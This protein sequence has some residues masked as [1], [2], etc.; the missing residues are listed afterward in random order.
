VAITTVCWVV[1]AYVGP[2]TD[3]GVLVNFWRKVRPFGPGW[4]PVRALVGPAALEAR[5]DGDNIPLALV[6]WLA[7]CTA[8][9]SALFAEG[10]YLYGRMPQAL[11]LTVVFLVS[12]A[13][14]AA[15]VRR[16]WASS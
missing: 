8:I 3:R 7:G 4:E 14:L 10:N 16:T 2:E 5:A 1:T 6:G 9:W 15:I 13:V 11:F 12:S